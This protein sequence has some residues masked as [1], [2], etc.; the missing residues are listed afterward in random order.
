MISHLSD[1]LKLISKLDFNW[2]WE[3]LTNCPSPSLHLA[4]VSHSS[5]IYFLVFSPCFATVQSSGSEVTTNSTEFRKSAHISRLPLAGGLPQ[6]RHLPG[7][8]LQRPPQLRA[9]GWLQGPAW[10]TLFPAQ[11]QNHRTGNSR[12][13]QWHGV[14]PASREELSRRLSAELAPLSAGTYSAPEEMPSASK[15][16]ALFR[17]VPFCPYST[18]A[19]APFQ[20]VLRAGAWRPELQCST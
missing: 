12:R 16:T 9:E 14:E 7:E 5:L 2:V 4:P 3:Q 1:T 19:E 10:H 17:P 13:D 6:Q 15:I 18:Y 8:V 11:A 20:I